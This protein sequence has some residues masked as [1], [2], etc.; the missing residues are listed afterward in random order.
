MDFEHMSVHHHVFNQSV[1]AQHN[2]GELLFL[3]A[4]CSCNAARQ[5]RR[6]LRVEHNEIGFATRIQIASHAA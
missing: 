2:H 5:Q 1:V 3:Q 4:V 6:G